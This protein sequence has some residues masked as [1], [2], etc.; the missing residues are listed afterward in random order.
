MLISVSATVTRYP[1]SFGRWAIGMLNEVYSF[2]EIAIVG[3]AAEQKAR[4]LQQ[5]FIPNKIIMAAADEH[6]EF[7]LLAGKSAQEKTLIYVCQN[8]ACQVPVENWSEHH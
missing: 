6:A 7:P 3:S 5:Q 1:A 2:K 8:Y 4:A